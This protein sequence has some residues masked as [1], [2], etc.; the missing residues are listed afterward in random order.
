MLG[1][2]PFEWFQIKTNSAPYPADI[3]AGHY[4]LYC[5]SDIVRHQLVGDAYAP[6]P[7]TV[8][9]QGK[10]GDIITQTFSP[11]YYLRVAK[12][13]VENI[14][15]EIQTDQN[16]PVHFTYGKCNVQLHFRPLQTR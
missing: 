3:K 1:I 11:A 8:P 16:Q 2:K 9:I 14:H 10:F 7:R 13:H 6:L 5:Y 12:K 4:Q 15:T